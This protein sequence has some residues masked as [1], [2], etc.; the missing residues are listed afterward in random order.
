MDGGSIAPGVSTCASISSS[1]WGSNDEGNG[2]DSATGISICSSSGSSS[3]WR[4]SSDSG[5]GRG[6]S[7]NRG[8]TGESRRRSG[9]CASK[10][11]YASGV[12]ELS[13][14]RGSSDRIGSDRIGISSARGIGDGERRECRWGGQG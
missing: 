8:C 14:T 4:G 6:S 10:S 9:G 12:V 11:S 2:R 13:I 5:N 3:V 7:G 1:V